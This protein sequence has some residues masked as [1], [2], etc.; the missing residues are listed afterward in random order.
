MSHPLG[1]RLNSERRNHNLTIDALAN[2]SGVSRSMI[3]KVERGEAQP[4]TS[5]LGKL[6]E[7]LDLSISQL[8]GGP[9][10]TGALVVRKAD[11][12][13]F[14]EESSGFERRSLSPLY[15]GRGIDLVLNTLPPNSRTGPFPSHRAGVEEHLWVQSGNLMVEVGEEQHHL[16]AGDFLFYPADRDHSFINNEDTPAVFMIAIDSTKLR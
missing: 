13:R 11:Q 9:Q 15:R 14:S 3:S 16:K 5:V 12:P 10:I 7:A 4:T 6:A 1:N 2:K 8:V